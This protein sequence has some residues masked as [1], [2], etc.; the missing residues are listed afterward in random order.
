[1]DA[2]KR[3]RRFT[4]IWVIS[5]L[6]P[7]LVIL[8]QILSAFR[9]ELLGLDPG[10]AGHNFSYNFRFFFPVVILSLL[11]SLVALILFLRTRDSVKSSGDSLT[12]LECLSPIPALIPLL[13]LLYIFISLISFTGRP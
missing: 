11:L 5:S 1:M 2:T 10:V 8:E 7:L 3:K 12:R 13:G 6:S 9:K 4:A